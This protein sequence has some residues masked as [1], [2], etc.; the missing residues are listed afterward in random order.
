M[1]FQVKRAALI[2]A[3]WKASQFANIWATHEYTIYEYN[4]KEVDCTYVHLKRCIWDSHTSPQDVLDINEDASSVWLPQ[5][6]CGHD[7]HYKFAENR[8][9]SCFVRKISCWDFS[10]NNSAILHNNFIHVYFLFFK[11]NKSHQTTIILLDI[12]KTLVRILAIFRNNQI[13]S[14]H[15]TRTHSIFRCC[16][17]NELPT[18]LKSHQTAIIHLLMVSVSAHKRHNRP[19]KER[20]KPFPF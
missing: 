15:S 1:A 3:M 17:S 8:L 16:W 14:L 5:R 19:R 2:W 18:Q 20:T 7:V 6:V 12:Y 4:L 10:K 9:K 11:H 13:N